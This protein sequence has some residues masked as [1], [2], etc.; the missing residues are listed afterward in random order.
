MAQP[1]RPIDVHQDDLCPPNKRYAVM[2][3][4]KKIDL[5]N[6]L[7]PNES[8]IIA[9]I[10]QNHPL[11]FSVATSSSVPWIYLGQFW[12][13]LQ[14]N[15]S[16]YWLKFM[17]D[18][19]ELT[20]T[21]NDFKRIFHVPQA[22]DNNHERFVAALKFLKMVPFSRNTLGFTLEAQDKYHN[23]KDDAMVNNI[24]N[25]RKHK[26]GVGMKIPS[27]MIT[28]EMKLTNHYRMLWYLGKVMINLKQ[29]EM[30]KNLRSTYL[31]AKEIEKFVEG[32]ENVENVEV[33]SSTLWKDD[34]QT[35]T[36]TWLEPRSD[37]ES[38]KGIIMERQQS[39]ADVAKMISDTIQ[40]E[41][42]N[43]R[44]MITPQ[45]ND[46]LSNHIPTQVDSSVRNY[47][48]GYILHLHPTQAT[49]TS[50]Q[51]QQ[52]LHLTM[53]DNPQLQQDDLPIWLALK[54]K[55]ERLHVATTPCISFAVRVRDK[56]DPRDDSNLEGENSLKRQKKSEHG[57]FKGSS[58]PEKIVISFHKFPVVIFLDEI[59]KKELP[60]GRAN[61][62][63]VS[64]I[65]S[66]YKHLNKN[67]IEDMYLLIVNHKVNL[68]APTITFPGIEKFKVFSII[69]EPVYGLIYKNN[70]K[71]K[72]VMRHQE[73][74]HR[75]QSAKERSYSSSDDGYVAWLRW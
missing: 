18:Q 30:Y 43:L 46:A 45:I 64:I 41:R 44:S 17:L 22:I 70:N 12:H 26:D 3:A 47:M 35:I 63:I 2:D 25:L 56:D 27:W 37:K 24:F 5:Y 74:D 75:D 32:A 7:Y 42:E 49:P 34:T 60:D 62:S 72:R 50:V 19:K 11:R 39:Q 69:S 40:Q 28:Y 31:I 13:T 48:S 33:N 55:F 65:E 38:T 51:E 54:Y 21:L 52:Q 59:L 68:T 15:G 67:N 73:F 23:S 1:Q 14:E 57:T 4:N 20:L 9:N 6:K 16:K 8:K 36:G 10:I 71:E 29:S 53:R 61:G 58:G 66:D